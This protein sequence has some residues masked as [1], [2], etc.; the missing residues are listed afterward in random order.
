M[1][2][3]SKR[4]GCSG[5]KQFKK[6][7]NVGKAMVLCEELMICPNEHLGFLREVLERVSKVD[8]VKG[9]MK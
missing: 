8:K 3:W 6:M 5:W 2:R 7:N 4:S 9:S 1:I